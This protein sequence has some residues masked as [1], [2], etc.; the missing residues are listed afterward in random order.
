[1][2]S[3]LDTKQIRHLLTT[4]DK[5]RRFAQWIGDHA[6]SL[7]QFVSQGHMRR[8]VSLWQSRRKPKLEIAPGKSGKKKWL[9][10]QV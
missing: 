10:S 5:Y 2:E 8:T 7:F 1:M 9:A 3:A 4:A 6:G